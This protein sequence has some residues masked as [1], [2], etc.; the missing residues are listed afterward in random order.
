MLQQARLNSYALH[1]KMHM[2]EISRNSGLA[3]YLGKARG[4]PSCL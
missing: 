3:P 1:G 2:G 4:N